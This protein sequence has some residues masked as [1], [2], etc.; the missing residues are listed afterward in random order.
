LTTNQKVRGS[1]P[2]GRVLLMHNL[3]DK[4]FIREALKEAKK[5]LKA[6]EVP[7]GAVAV[8]SGRIIS[9]GYNRSI[10]DNDPSAH[11]EIVVLRK[12]SKTLKNY[13]LT[14]CELYVT[15]E[16]CAMCA[17]ALVLARIKRIIFGAYDKKGGACG[18]IFNIAAHKA[19]NH[20]IEIVPG[21]LKNEC[22][23][24]IK[25]FFKSKRKVENIVRLESRE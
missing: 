15:V 11:A 16:P 17:G 23:S 22:S 18:S 8:K 4:K 12:A 3:R 20:R 2:L 21:I 10:T 19:L 25:D 24:L 14:G 9:R 6:G 1:S 5:A 13:R 7:V